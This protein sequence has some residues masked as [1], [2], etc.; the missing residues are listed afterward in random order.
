MGSGLGNFARQ[1]DNRRTISTV[2]I[3]HY[4]RS[5]VAGH[6]GQWVLGDLEGRKVLAVRGRIHFYEGYPMPMVAFPVRI[7]AEL[8]TS[9]LIVTNAAGS[10]NPLF[11]PG[12]LMLI[13]DH[14]NLL[15]RNPLI[16]PEPVDA[17][18]RFVD[19]SA[20]YSPELTALA[21]AVALGERI[22]L[23][24]GVLVASTGPTYE[25]RAEVHM[26]RRLGADAATMSTVPEVIVANQLGLK[27]L[28]ISCIT[29]LATG[30][31][32]APL[33]HGEVTEVASLVAQKFERLVRAI[34]SRIYAALE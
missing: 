11:Q 4:P 32:A 9:H 33:D 26:L 15:F 34:I 14:I 10:L 20:P 23:R 7:L 5:T 17:A 22:P 21:E 1:L 16:M 13:D 6:A 29:N 25:T 28:G 12:D 30:L 3:P 31:S 19:M 27:V 18:S 8:G 24:R 2:D